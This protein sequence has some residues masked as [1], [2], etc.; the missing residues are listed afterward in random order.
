[1]GM[2]RQFHGIIEKLLMVKKLIIAI[3]VKF[4]TR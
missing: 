1:M 3:I 2:E 4:I